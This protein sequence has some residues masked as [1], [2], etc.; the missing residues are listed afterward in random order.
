[1][2]LNVVQVEEIR[3]LLL[4]VPRLVDGLEAHESGFINGVLDWLKAAEG[5]LENNRLAAVSQVATLR[6]S[7][8]EAIRGVRSSELVFAGRPTARKVREATAAEV[9]Q[10]GTEL[11]H[12]TIAEREAVFQ[13]AERIA[14]Q[15]MAVAHAKGLLASHEAD[16]PRHS[17]SHLEDRVAADPDLTAVH[18]HLI[19]LVGSADI[20][21][22]LDRALP[23]V[24]K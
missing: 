19:A 5:I 17:L 22:F 23:T 4:Q 20:L 8:I 1:M 16:G 6:A 12:T 18:A 13:E 14:R 7:L 21:I 11:M 9:L 2:P 15:I 10:R 24:G 3:D